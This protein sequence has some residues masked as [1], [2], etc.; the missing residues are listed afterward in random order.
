MISTLKEMGFVAKERLAELE[1]NVTG[2][3]YYVPERAQAWRKGI[4]IS[5]DVHTKNPESFGQTFEV[6][7]RQAPQK[8]MYTVLGVKLIRSLF[9]DR[10]VLLDVYVHLKR[11][12][13]HPSIQY[14]TA[15]KDVLDFT[16]MYVSYKRP[17]SLIQSGEIEEGSTLLRYCKK[18]G[19][20]HVMKQGTHYASP[21]SSSVE[22]LEAI[23]TT[24]E[25]KSVLE[26]GGGVGTCGRAA[27]FNGIRDFTF[28]DVN[29]IACQYLRRHFTR[30][31][32]AEENAFTFQ[33]NRHW[34]VILMGIGYLQNPWFLEKRGQDLADHCS[35]VIFQS[36]ITTFCEFE[37]DWICGKAEFAPWPWWTVFQTL[38]PYFPHVW[39]TSFDWQT[40]VIG[41]HKN[42]NVALL[43][44][45]MRQRG[46]SE[47]QYQRVIL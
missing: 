33:F 4:Y 20:P 32:V 31:R 10:E 34:D 1:L 7:R 18:Y 24:Q 26:I 14:A 11:P 38:R 42:V 22:A 5:F 29:P 41:A 21:D 28:V 6:A 35:V 43:Q 30:F 37:H 23:C 16:E 12:M 44:K 39:E 40:C 9:P 19:L 46:F 15:T 45:R 2:V 47:I 13:S 25:V 17:S 8:L 27:Q 3:H 36:G